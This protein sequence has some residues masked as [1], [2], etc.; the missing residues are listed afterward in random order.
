MADIYGRR[1]SDGK[2]KRLPNVHRRP[3]DLRSSSMD[4]YAP[5]FVVGR[6]FVMNKSIVRMF[7]FFI[8]K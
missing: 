3:S 5:D 6:R 2:T 8:S 1:R 4:V 7:A